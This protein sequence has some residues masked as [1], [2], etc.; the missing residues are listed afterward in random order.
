MPLKNLRTVLQGTVFAGLLA[1]VALPAA[2]APASD[3]IPNFTP[4]RDTSWQV[5]FW[6]Y[7]LPP[8]PGAAHGPILT[9]PKYP[10]NSQIQNGGLFRGGD[11]QVAIV[12]AKDPVLKPW[13][14][15]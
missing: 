11:F 5:N 10:Y 15:K 13:A 1:V 4:A 2:S 7:I 3:N 14:A 8:P 12:N 9:D 6:D